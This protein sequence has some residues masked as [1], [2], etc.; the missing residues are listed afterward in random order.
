[1]AALRAD[2]GA[3]LTE[4][5]SL[6]DMLQR[7]AIALHEH[8]GASLARIWMLDESERVLTLQAN[9][10]TSTSVNLNHRR[11]S[12]GQYKVGWIAQHRQPYLTN[13]VVTDP[14]TSDREWAKR[15]GIVA[16]AGYP[17]TIK[18]RL[19]GVM[20]IFST[21]PITEQSLR[22][23]AA[24]A[25]AVAVGID[26]KVAAEVL[27]QTA[28]RERTVALILRRMRETLNLETIFHTTTSELRQAIECDR[29]LVYQFDA[30]WSGQVVAESVGDRWTPMIP[31][32]LNN[33]ELDQVV[34]RAN[35]I[36][37]QLDDTEVLIRD[38]YLQE[39]QGGLYRQKSNYCCVTDIYQQ[40][41]D[42]C[43]LELLEALQ[44]RAYIIVP[45]FCGNQLWGLLATY[46]NARPRQWQLAE[47]QMVSQIGNQ[48]GVAVQQVELFVQTQHQA[49]ELQQAKEAA[50]FAN[51]A[52]SE[53]LANMS[54]ELRTPLN[55]ILGFTQL[56]QQDS[57]LSAE[58]QRSVKI[59]SQSGEHLLGL[60]NDVLEMSKIEAGQVTLNKTDCDL[61]KLLHSLEDML[62]LKARSKGLHLQFDWD[63]TTPQLVKTDENKLRQVLINLLGNAVKFTQEG[64]VTLRL[65]VETSDSAFCLLSFEVEDTGV[66][67]AADELGDLFE[68]FKQTRSGQQSQEGTGLGLRIS[69]RFVQL[70][71]G[72]ISVRSEFGKG[73]CFAFQIPVEPPEAASLKATTNA[74]RTAPFVEFAPRSI[75][76]RILI[77]EDHPANRLL[78][79]ALLEDWGFE[80]Q[81]AEDGQAAIEL[82]QQWQPHLI[83][84]DMHM[85]IVNGYEAT[86]KI[87]AL[88]QQCKGNQSSTK[89][90]AL[91]ASAFAEQRQ[92]SIAAGCDDFISK[93]F[94]QEELLKALF[95]HLGVS[96]RETVA[97]K[98]ASCHPTTPHQIDR[99]DPTILATMSSDWIAQMCFAAAQ[100]NDTASLNLI[101][102][103]P[104]EHQAS[105]AA[106]THLVENYQFDSILELIELIRVETR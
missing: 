92:E 6:H 14:R 1:M 39:N 91:T 55:A 46:Q 96:N 97:E 42:H 90:I 60:I 13:Q 104:S 80:I 43:Y 35:C 100:G 33:S 47:I 37:K 71:G 94:Q 82:W 102:Q 30:N 49:A 23:M 72:K 10:G 103:I 11:V 68:A 52:K 106:L 15:E 19:L 89:I 67:I 48:L 77:V 20:A 95:Q 44:A 98:S 66:G 99:I 31:L 81:E 36:V 16:F 9:A 3:A 105:I 56:M 40:G 54:H 70:M 75:E 64:S 83:L 69:Q 5:E 12:V 76:H 62:Q 27:W 51:R 78:L 7:C 24:I 101:A 8:L 58:H 87:R 18:N 41:F 61:H 4:A 74:F 65:K 63:A 88:E 26:R 53:F 79:N 86:R 22:E 73:S 34:D 84:M 32:P 38:T 50:D 2:I 28:E 21:Q 25:S 57:S 17:L 93:P 59:V 85:P 45:I 29:V